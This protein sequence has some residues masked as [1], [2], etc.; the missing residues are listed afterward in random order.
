LTPQR[1]SIEERPGNGSQPA[2]PFNVN[3][4]V[5]TAHSSPAGHG[6]SQRSV[7]GISRPESLNEPPPEEHT[8]AQIVS[9]AIERN[10]D[11]NSLPFY[12][13]T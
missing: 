13:G 11:S 3:P 8:G 10:N 12:I 2:Q 6:Q 7:N 5:G 9:A 1:Q 4:V